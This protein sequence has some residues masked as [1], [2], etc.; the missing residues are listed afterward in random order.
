VITFTVDL[1]D[2]TARY[3]TSGRFRTMTRRILAMCREFQRPATFF[4]IGRIAEA[5]PDLIQEIARDGHEI[6]YHSHAHVFLTHEDPARFRRESREDKDRLEQ[7]AGKSVLGFRAPGFSLTPHSVWALDVLAEL[8]FLYSSSIMPT[9]ISR[10]GFPGAPATPFLWPNGLIELPLPIAG[11][12]GLPYLGGIYLYAAPWAWT[13]RQI[14]KASPGE[15]LWTYT[16][17][18]DFD[19]TEKFSPMPNTPFWISLLLWLARRK[20]EGK[21]WKILGLGSAP[22]LGERAGALTS[23][24]T[25]S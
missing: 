20:A 15:T 8:G 3:E 4:V 1:E 10:F 17:P 7:L 24:E 2:P 18:Y 19:R 21:V 16:H 14:L 22:T 23:L 25:Y 11:P 13:K 5:A 12:W 9:K 6:A